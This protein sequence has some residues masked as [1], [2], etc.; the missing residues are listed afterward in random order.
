MMDGRG[1]QLLGRELSVDI[2][3]AYWHVPAHPSS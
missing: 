1:S 2:S 3:A